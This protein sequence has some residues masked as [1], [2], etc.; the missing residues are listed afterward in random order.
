MKTI[1]FIII[2]LFISC[3]ITKPKTDTNSPYGVK[4]MEVLT[5]APND[6]WFTESFEKRT[7]DKQILEKL[8]SSWDKDIEVKLFMGTWCTDSK[9]ETPKYYKMLE[10]AGISKESTQLIIVDRD[11]H[12]PE[13]AEKGLKIERVPTIIFYKKGKEIGRIVEYSVQT[14]EKDILKIISGQPYKHAYQD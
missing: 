6:K 12:T 5:K 1:F 3:N 2:T 9:I 7:F 4:N 10:T 13:R 8:K 14:M 11:K